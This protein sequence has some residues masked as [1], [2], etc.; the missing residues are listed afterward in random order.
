MAKGDD[1]VRKKQNKVKR[2]KLHNKNDRSS[3][4]IS[5]RVASIIAA[6]AIP[7]NAANVRVCALAFPPLMIPSTIGMVQRILRRE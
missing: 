3:S 7:V 4:A 1:A 2:K 5:A 6:A